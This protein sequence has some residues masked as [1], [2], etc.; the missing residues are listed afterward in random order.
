MQERLKRE[1]EKYADYEALKEKATKYDEAEAMIQSVETVSNDY[2][3]GVERDMIHLVRAPSFFGELCTY[4]D[5]VGVTSSNL[6]P[7]TS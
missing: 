5:T 6:V 4:L 7:P 1:R 2:V 3:D